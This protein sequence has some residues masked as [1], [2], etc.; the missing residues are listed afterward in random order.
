MGTGGISGV[1]GC[2]FNP[3]SSTVGQRLW[4]EDPISGP[5]LYMPQGSR[6]R[7]KQTNNK[8]LSKG[9]FIFLENSVGETCFI[10]SLVGLDIYITGLF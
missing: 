2:R 7:N 9:P 5:E 3:W 8:N 10:H 6:K 4:L 1:L